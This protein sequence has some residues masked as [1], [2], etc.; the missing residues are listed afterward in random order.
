M[1]APQPTLIHTYVH[2]YTVDTD[3]NKL[4]NGINKLG[5]GKQKVARSNVQSCQNRIDRSRLHCS[6]YIVLITS[7]LLWLVT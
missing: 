2:T 4:K 1:H 7:E 6:I 3:T 5:E